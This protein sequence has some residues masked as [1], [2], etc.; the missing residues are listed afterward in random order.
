M[1]KLLLPSLKLL[2]CTAAFFTPLPPAAVLLGL[3]YGEYGP[4]WELMAVLLV[5]GGA[6][7]AYGRLSKRASLRRQAAVRIIGF[8]L[9]LLPLTAG[10]LLCAD[11]GILYGACAAVGAAAMCYVGWQSVARPYGEVFTKN[12]FLF[13]VLGSLLGMLVLVCFGRPLPQ[14]QLLCVLGYGTGV[15]ILVRNQSNIDFLMER[16]RHR[17]EHLPKRIRYFNL[18]AAFALVALVFALFLGKDAVIAGVQGGG[19]LLWHGVRQVLQLLFYKQPGESLPET[20]ENGPAV[21][22]GLPE[23]EAGQKVFPVEWVYLFF[24]VAA[25]VILFCNRRRI[26]R[27]LLRSGRRVA[28]LLRRLLRGRERAPRGDANGYYV[29]E[30]ETLLPGASE[31]NPGA[32]RRGVRQ[33]RREY[34][35]FLRMP[36]GEEALRRGLV[37]AA[38]WSTL[39]KGEVPPGDT[40]AELLQ[41]IEARTHSP[42]C[43]PAA[44]GYNRVRYGALSCREEDYA[45]MR[46]ALGDM[47]EK[48][49]G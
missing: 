49:R 22:P 47:R 5:S 6:G 45:A 2:A 10:W 27:F 3:T 9:L 20:G 11:Y 36:Q 14:A 37:L 17:M 44:E 30:E 16:R 1:K 8:L 18:F 7:F 43:A 39:T 33:W 21:T 46:R 48:I 35:R 29:D 23:A 34:Q 24:A 42:A 41:K 32:S 12:W 19:W 4:L 25:I 15:Y 13:C 38:W 40:A 26:G 31:E 28:E